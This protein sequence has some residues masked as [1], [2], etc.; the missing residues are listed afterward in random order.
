M[1]TAPATYGCG[2]E[3]TD[4][5]RDCDRELHIT[6]KELKVV[7][8]AVLTFLSEMRGRQ[9][10][11]REDNMGVVHVLAN[12]TSRSPL[13]MTELG[14]DGAYEEMEAAAAAALR[15]SRCAGPPAES[16]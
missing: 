6:Y 10:L 2:Y 3:T 12:L 11:L 5:D 1:S 15:A 7:R 13:F 14:G 16:A 8:Y 4:C 9:V